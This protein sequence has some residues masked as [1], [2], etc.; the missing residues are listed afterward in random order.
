MSEIMRILSLYD[1][2]FDLSK[3][4]IGDELLYKPDYLDHYTPCRVAKEPF[5]G[6]TGVHIKLLSDVPDHKYREGHGI[7]GGLREIFGTF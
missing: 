1:A 3:L 6:A 7:I 4:E 2:D 5:P